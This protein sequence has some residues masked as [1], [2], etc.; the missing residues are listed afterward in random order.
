MP[1]RGHGEDSD[2]GIARSGKKHTCMLNMQ[3][4]SC[5]LPMTVFNSLLT[6][7]HHSAASWPRP[8]L[9]LARPTAAGVP[10]V[11]N[12]DGSVAK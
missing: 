8:S 12:G 6:A 2:S 11:T 3:H 4:F 9:P 1:G 5:F 7:Q 10:A